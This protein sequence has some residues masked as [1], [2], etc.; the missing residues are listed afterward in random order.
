V[1]QIAKGIA[2]DFNNLLCTISGHAALV[3]RAKQATPELAASAA[4]IIRSAERGI[5]LAGHLLELAP[6]PGLVGS[7]T[8]MIGDHIRNAAQALRDS[9]S[10]EWQVDCSIDEQL[11]PV[12]IPGM[13]IEQIVLNL[14]L[15]AA[16]AVPGAGKL[17]ISAAKPGASRLFDVS[18]KYACAIVF[19][20][21]ADTVATEESILKETQGESGVM[22]SI[23][24]SIIE[25][26]GGTLDELTA[27]DGKAV[28]RVALPHGTIPVEHADA[29]QIATELKAYLAELG[30]KV[31]RVD[32]VMSV[33]ARIEEGRGLDVAIIEKQL[34]GQEAKA[35]LRAIL[36]LR[37]SAGM[38]VLCEDTGTEGQE[39]PA[40]IVVAGV[41]SSLNTLL[42]AMIEAKSMALK[43]RTD[44][45]IKNHPPSG[46]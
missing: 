17:R 1:G 32:N 24:R 26:A 3:G 13:Q 6:H 33:L 42:T 34:L 5:A 31:E 7:L 23:I 38:V 4:A 12:A 41:S 9:L 14:G 36:R 22:L 11:P 29:S 21:S 10:V 16:D 2:H 25:E 28:Y 8:Y 44:A 45:E 27:A 40:D 37:P 35:L 39:L 15:L 20:A 19:F 30:A 18:S 46:Q 43:R